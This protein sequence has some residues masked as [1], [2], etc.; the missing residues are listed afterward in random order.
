MFSIAHWHSMYIAVQCQPAAKSL[1]YVT[2]LV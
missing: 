2:T 1:C